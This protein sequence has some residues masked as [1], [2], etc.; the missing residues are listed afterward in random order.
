MQNKTKWAIAC[1]S[2]SAALIAGIKSHE[3]YRAKP[4]HDVGKVATVG[5]GSTQYADGRRVKI[6]DAPVG[7]EQAEKMLRAH[8]AK[9]EGRL[10]AMLPGVYLSA[11]EYDVY[12]DFVYNFG[13]ANF[14]KSS[15]R[16]NL[17]AGNHKAACQSLLKYK[18]AGG[19]DCSI[20]KNGCYGVWT[21]QV[22]RHK[23]CMEANT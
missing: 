12:A 4:Y 10:K 16:R 6:T 8:V 2:A 18:Y 21:R 23:K 11:A 14:Q 1:L 7:R 22:S 5:Y 13:A 20:R 19:R 15:M 3:G 9:D 17:L